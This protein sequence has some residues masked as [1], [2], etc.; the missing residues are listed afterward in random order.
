VR[1][2]IIEKR[3]QNLSRL[4]TCSS[5]SSLL[6]LSYIP[7][8]IADLRSMIYTS[9]IAHPACSWRLPYSD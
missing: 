7:L 4:T 2:L 3:V 5:Y 1:A 8:L 6:P 9:Y